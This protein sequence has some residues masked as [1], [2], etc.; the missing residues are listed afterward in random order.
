MRKKGGAVS[1]D[2][3]GQSILSDVA[4]LDWPSQCGSRGVAIKVY[5]EGVAK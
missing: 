1:P 5:L 2:Y 4:C 3:R